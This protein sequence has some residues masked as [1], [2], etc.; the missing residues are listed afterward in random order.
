MIVQLPRMQIGL[1]IWKVEFA[2]LSEMWNSQ[3]LQIPTSIFYGDS[4]TK[5]RSTLRYLIDRPYITIIF[6]CSHFPNNLV[7]SI[8]IIFIII[9]T[10]PIHASHAWSLGHCPH[11]TLDVE[12]QKWSECGYVQ[13]NPY[14]HLQSTWTK[15]EKKNYM[16]NLQ[17]ILCCGKM[18]SSCC[19]CC[20]RRRH[21]KGST[22]TSLNPL[23][24]TPKSIIVNEDRGYYHCLLLVS[25]WSLH[26]VLPLGLPYTYHNLLGQW[27]KWPFFAT[28]NLSRTS[29]F[30]FNDQS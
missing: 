12:N 15:C 17:Q 27:E 9:I 21:M 23:T 2:F 24:T 18:Y 22:I 10:W 19:C 6:G 11:G 3:P 7:F 26:W 16:L 28:L 5:P 14:S 25:S 20:C 29:K 1:L 4:K 13:P 8:Y 30:L